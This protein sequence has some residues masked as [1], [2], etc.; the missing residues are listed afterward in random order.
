[1]RLDAED[2]DDLRRRRHRARRLRHWIGDLGMVHLEAVLEPHVGAPIVARLEAARRPGDGVRFEQHLADAF[3]DGATGAGGDPK[4]R[5]GNA[6]VVVLVSHEVTRREWSDVGDGEICS[7]PGVG[8]IHPDTAREIAGDAFLSGVFYDGTDLRH[9]KRWTRSVPPEVRLALRLGEPP[10]FDGPR[11]VDCGGRLQL[12]VDH[13]EPYAAGG[14]TSLGNSDL[15]CPPCHDAKTRAD[16]AA[17]RDRRR[18]HE[19]RSRRTRHHQAALAAP[20]E[21]GQVA[22]PLIE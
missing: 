20:G 18:H 14:P 17:L 15:R 6:E 9:L 19:E 7:I 5:R 3:A 22:M 2:P 21:A 4:R 1:M 8:P 10:A 12:E 13:R 11:C 16:M